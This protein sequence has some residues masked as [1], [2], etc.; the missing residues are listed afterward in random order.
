MNTRHSSKLSF[1]STRCRSLLLGRSVRVERL[2]M[3]D[4]DQ[5]VSWSLEVHALAH[6]YGSTPGLVS[7]E[8]SSYCC[9]FAVGHS[10]RCS[11]ERARLTV[12]IG[13]GVIEGLDG[14]H[15]ELYA[16]RNAMRALSYFGPS[17]KNNGEMVV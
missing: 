15:G 12:P 16:G 8:Q 7:R 5:S 3:I 17:A 1:R 10:A 11:I 9:F 2:D 13:L 14:R 4:V 6:M